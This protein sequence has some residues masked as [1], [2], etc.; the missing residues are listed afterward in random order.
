MCF[1]RDI[2]PATTVADDAVETEYRTFNELLNRLL[3]ESGVDYL[4]LP[5]KDDVLDQRAI[6]LQQE[7]LNEI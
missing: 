3:R 1:N 6:P 2:S 5:L 7:K 4:P